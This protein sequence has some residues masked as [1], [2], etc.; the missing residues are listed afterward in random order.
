MEQALCPLLPSP[1]DVM[2]IYCEETAVLPSPVCVWALGESLM[3]PL[4]PKSPHTS[5]LS[6]PCIFFSLCYSASFPPSDW[7]VLSVPRNHR[8][9]LHSLSFS[10]SLYCFIVTHVTCRLCLP[11]RFMCGEGRT[12]QS[13][14]GSQTFPLRMLWDRS[15]ALCPA[16]GPDQT[17]GRTAS[18]ASSALTPERELSARYRD[19]LLFDASGLSRTGIV[20]AVGGRLDAQTCL[21]L[22]IPW[23]TNKTVASSRGRGTG[24]PYSLNT[25]EVISL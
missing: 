19:Q 10:L 22:R 11:T 15:A 23:S 12:W 3:S 4:V 21:T 13:S 14:S 5:C 24:R 17:A 18:V 1:Y 25:S 20:K 2:S 8:H 7:K 6:C 9:H 16:A